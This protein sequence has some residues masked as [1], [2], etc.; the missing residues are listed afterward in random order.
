MQKL[1]IILF[2]F[3]GISC[4]KDE[5]VRPY[6]ILSVKFIED[7]E[8]IFIKSVD[9]SWDKGVKLAQLSASGY[10]SEWFGLYLPHLSDTGYYPNP[11]ISNIYYFDGLDFMPFKLTGGFIH[12][13]Y[14]DSVTVR[15]DFKVSF[16]DDFNGAENRTVL[17]GFGI[18][19]H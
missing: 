11:T 19:I 8:Y 16:E 6:S 7:E 18:N 10:K 9:G 15:G 3:I 13:S 4:K 5:T 1:A 17:G 14:I 12:V 2:L